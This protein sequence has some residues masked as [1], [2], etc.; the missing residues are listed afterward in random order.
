[1][2]R[3]SALRR[4]TGTSEN[5]R[6]GQGLRACRPESGAAGRHQR[7]AGAPAEVL[8]DDEGPCF[9]PDTRA[10]GRPKEACRRRAGISKRPTVSGSGAGSST[11]RPELR[12]FHQAEQIADKPAIV[13]HGRGMLLRARD[14]AQLGGGR[15]LT[16]RTDAA[17]LNEAINQLRKG[18]DG[19]HGS[20][21]QG[22]RCPKRFAPTSRRC[23][24]G[25]DRSGH[26]PR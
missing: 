4:D 13:R 11:S 2:G 15:I 16:R 24:G 9:G 22:L 20:C 17:G 5:I 3:P 6:I 10:G 18:P 26:R 7:L 25:Q 23:G 12:D 1:M 19:R 8:L 14:G 21:E